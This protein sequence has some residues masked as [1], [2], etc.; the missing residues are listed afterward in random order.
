MG[1]LDRRI[2]GLTTQFPVS[3]SSSSGG[4]GITIT[5][6][7]SGYILKATGVANPVEGIPNLRWDSTN[8]ALSASGDVYISGS[9]N[10]LYLHGI[11]DTGATVRFKVDIAGNILKVIGE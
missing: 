4:G 5:N 6:N 8:T 7:V 3:G 2:L 9:S 1:I 11:D 10:Y